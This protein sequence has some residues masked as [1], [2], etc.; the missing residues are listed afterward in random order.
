MDTNRASLTA[1]LFLFCLE[2]DFMASLYD[3]KQAEIVQALNSTSRYPD[4]L[5]KE[6]MVH[7]IYQTTVQLEHCLYIMLIPK[8]N[9]SIS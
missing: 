3:D 8:P 1:D 2:R 5:S 4:D 6:G 7:L 9:L